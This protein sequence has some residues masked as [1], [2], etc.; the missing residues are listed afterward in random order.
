MGIPSPVW[1]HTQNEVHLSNSDATLATL[2]SALL[3]SLG[4]TQ[5]IIHFTPEGQVLE[6]NQ[7]FLDLMG[8]T[9]D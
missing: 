8:Y 6:A 2:Q 1:F 7:V 3:E 5:A 4:Q 9:I